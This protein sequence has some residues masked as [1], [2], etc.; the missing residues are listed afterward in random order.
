MGQD[1]EQNGDGMRHNPVVVP[2][3]R[4]KKKRGGDDF[5]QINTKSSRKQKSKGPTKQINGVDLPDGLEIPEHWMKE[6]KNVEQNTK[7]P[8]SPSP[9]KNSTKKKAK[10]H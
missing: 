6:L 8:V 10:K 7:I 2:E 1:I 4:K 5:D 3:G 9:K